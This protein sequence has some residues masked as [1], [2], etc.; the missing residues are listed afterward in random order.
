MGGTRG[1]GLF[2]GCFP[3]DLAEISP[4]RV[5]WRKVRDLR[6][7][8]GDRGRL[9]PPSVLQSPQVTRSAFSASGGLEPPPRD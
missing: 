8:G 3:G 2:P 1:E 9:G 4:G 7:A 5:G 6:M